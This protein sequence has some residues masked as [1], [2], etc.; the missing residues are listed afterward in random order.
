[1]RSVGKLERTKLTDLATE[2]LLTPAQMAE[3]DR[4][5]IKGGTR[6]LKLMEAAGKA[7]ADVIVEHYYQRSVLVLCGGGNNGGDGFVVARLLKDKGWPV[8]L[9]L[10]GQRDALKGDAAAM[11]AQ[12]QGRTERPGMVDLDDA[13]LIVDALLGAGLDRDIE[14]EL[15]ALIGAVN[16]SGKP[17][18]S[19]DMPSGVDGASGIVRGVAVDADATVTFFR[20]KP[21]HLLQPGR[22]LCG[23]TSI[24]DIGIS[25]SVLE[26]INATT[27]YNSPNLWQTP[28]MGSCSNKFDRG[29]CVV[30]SGP[31]LQTGASR[32]SALGALRIGAGLVS[33]VGAADALLVHA[34]HV[35]A[36]MLKA[37]EDN[38]A[39]AQLLGDK[40]INVVVLG[41]AAGIGA[42][43]RANVL[44][45]L[46]SGAAA[47]LDADALTSFKDDAEI[48]FAAIKVKERSVVLTPHEGEFERLF[49]HVPGSKLDRARSAAAYSGAI[50]VLKGSDTVIAAPDGRAAINGNAPAYLGTAGAGDVLA[51][52]VGGLLAQGMAGFEAAA[53]GVWIHAEAAN[54]F[55]GAGMISE[56]LPH[57]IP[58]VLAQL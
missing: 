18:V 38:A 54:D 20:R 32:L 8:Q 28:S 48:L 4:L 22:D 35:T 52:M 19:I 41:P 7:V 39:L 23:K 6:S 24:I 26:K 10:F 29:H 14:G 9:R 46:K 13:D 31:S 12:W 40:R 51:G 53:A 36:I 15:A 42:Q 11:A 50:I 25:D 49:G 21:G 55:G 56:D 17:V 33:L 5:T 34:A 57:F 45:V 3:A 43:T 16:A 30:V 2:I 44:S 47:V 1:M 37:A 27:W 58:G